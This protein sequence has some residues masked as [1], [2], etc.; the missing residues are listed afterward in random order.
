[1]SEHVRGWVDPEVA[2]EFPDLELVQTTVPVGTG[3]SAPEIRERL[4]YLSQRMSGGEA[5]AFRTRPIPQAYRVLFRH[6]GM[7]PDEQRPP[8]EAVIV[9]RLIKGEYAAD[10]RLDDAITIAVAET[11]VPVWGL[12]EDRVEG[13]LGMRPARAGETVGTDQHA[14]EVPGGRL[15]LADEARTVG[16]LFGKLATS[17]LV[18]RQTRS[19][20]LF[21]IRAP[22]VPAIHLEEALFTCAECLALPGD[23]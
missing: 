20:R 23:S 22:S 10:N 8:G 11:G 17:H 1:M 12:D 7:D 6:L 18:T 15:V 9:E 4:R 14:N 21:A 2:A 13:L 16:V 5:V 19:T 3:R